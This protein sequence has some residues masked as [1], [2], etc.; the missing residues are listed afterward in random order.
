MST[1]GGT[2]AKYASSSARLFVVPVGL[3]GAAMKTSFVR[4]VIAREDGLEIEPIVAQRNAHGHAA[5]LE[6]VEHVA[7]K[8]R[9]A[10]DRLVARIERDHGQVADHRIRPRADRD[11]LEADAVPLRERVSEPPGP[12]VRIP[13]KLERRARDRLPG[14]RKRPERALVGRELDDALEPL[15]ALDF[16]YG[17]A[18]LVGNEPGDGT[19]DHRRIDVAGPTTHAAGRGS[20]A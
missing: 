12:A 6:G 14:S 15:L 4:G 2:S 5:E 9:P 3:F 13:V 11:V 7:R 20:A 1:C 18:G 10:G 16:L 8:R 19:A 17:L